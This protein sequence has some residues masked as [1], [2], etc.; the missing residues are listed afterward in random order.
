MLLLNTY[1]R[2]LKITMQSVFCA[3]LLGPTKYSLLGGAE[4]EQV[5]RRQDNNRE[6]NININNNN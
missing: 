4:N 6:N 5:R 3:Q 1:D 2:M